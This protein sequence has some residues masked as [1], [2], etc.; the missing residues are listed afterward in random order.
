[1]SKV[2]DVF[3]IIVRLDEE[4]QAVK[5]Q[6]GRACSSENS[7]FIE[8]DGSPTRTIDGKEDGKQY[9]T[10]T[11]SGITPEGTEISGVFF[12]ADAAIDNANLHL[13]RYLRGKRKVWWRNRI[14]VVEDI[15]SYLRDCTFDTKD[16]VFKTV[17]VYKAMCRVYAE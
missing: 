8:M 12:S 4:L 9:I 17:I 16:A 7:D 6:V 1:M 15:N 13:S 14:K 11:S 5:R 3:D 10:I 2:E